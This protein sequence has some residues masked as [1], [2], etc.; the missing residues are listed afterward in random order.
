MLAYKRLFD[1]KIWSRRGNEDLNLVLAGVVKVRIQDS[2]P[3]NLQK[4]H[5]CVFMIAKLLIGERRGFK[6]HGLVGGLYGILVKE[7][8]CWHCKLTV[9]AHVDDTRAC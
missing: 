6:P 3:A 7:P 4:G 8:I 9:Y 2:M 5:T 1:L